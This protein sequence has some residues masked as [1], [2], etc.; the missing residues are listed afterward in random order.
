MTKK[1]GINQ[2]SALTRD[3]AE[4]KKMTAREEKLRNEE[5]VK[6]LDEDKNLQRKAQ[7]KA[8]QQEKQRNIEARQA[9]KKAL[10]EAEERSLE[11]KSRKQKITHFMIQ[12]ELENTAKN[13]SLGKIPGYVPPVDDIE[14]EF[15]N[16]KERNRELLHVEEI[17]ASG[18][19]RVTS[20]IDRLVIGDEKK[21]NTTY[22]DYENRKLS[23]LKRRLA[24]LRLSQYKEI[25]WSE[26][27]R[28]PENP[29]NGR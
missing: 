20:T 2:K 27:K 5:N 11:L 15:E 22:K 25:L 9:E 1:F 24:G 17:H 29:A 14:L 21:Q 10:R 16:L 8:E 28:S 18:L 7:R 13:S 23:A 12:K 6:W 3:R 4:A 26:W 19:E